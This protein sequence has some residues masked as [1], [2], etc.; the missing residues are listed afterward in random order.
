MIITTLIILVLLGLFQYTPLAS[1]NDLQL[2]SQA[3]SQEWGVQRIAKD[4]LVMQNGTPFQRTQVVSELQTTLPEWES[5][6]KSIQNSNQSVDI[7]VLL[8]STTTD[9]SAIDTAAKTILARSDQAA[10]A[11]Q[12]RIITDH[13]EAYFST[14]AQ[15]V[16][17]T[18]QRMLL[19]TQWLFAIEI[20]LGAIIGSLE[21]WRLFAI[22][23]L[24]KDL[25]KPEQKT[26]V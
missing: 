14:I 6:Q 2:L 18:Q 10:D 21:V 12:V 25:A 3:T 11:T 5:T 4:A 24:V 22:E 8:A 7:Q 17:I 16:A 13:T 26:S 23:R 20:T 1:G 15:I 19:R 9:F